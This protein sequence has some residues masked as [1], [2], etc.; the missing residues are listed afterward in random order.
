MS[1]AHFEHVVI[2]TFYTACFKKKNAYLYVILLLLK[3]NL[4]YFMQLAFS[5]CE[6]GKMPDLGY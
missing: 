5:K 1:I 3:T 6:E 2:K 4:T